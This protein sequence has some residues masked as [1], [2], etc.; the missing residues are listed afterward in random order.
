MP[1]HIETHFARL[2]EITNRGE[3]PWTIQELS[4][5]GFVA[6]P[7]GIYKPKGSP[8]A[9]SVRRTI[10]SPYDDPPPLVSGSRFSAVYREEREQ[11]GK[12]PFTVKALFENRD[13]LAP[14]LAYFNEVT[15]PDHSGSRLYELT[16]LAIVLTYQDGWFYLEGR[17][18]TESDVS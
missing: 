17:S 10:G 13:H 11:H 8:F 18:T 6:K 3:G 16:G 14:P 7:K 9:L 5:A 2:S 12:H 1:G 4:T 15:P